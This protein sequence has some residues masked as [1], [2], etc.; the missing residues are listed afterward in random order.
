MA[1]RVL[2]I[3]NNL[4]QASYRLR[5]AALV[6]PLSR[7]GIEILVQV[8]PREWF[9]RRHLLQSAGDFDAVLLQRKMLDPWDMRTLRRRAKRIVYDVDDAVMYQGGQAGWFNRRLN[10]RRFIST[11]RRVDLVVAG[12]EY[13]ADLFRAQG[14]SAVVLPTCVDPNHYQVKASE[15]ANGATLVWIGSASTIPYLRQSLP[16]LAKAALAA[17]GLR[18]LTIADQSLPHSP[19]PLEHVTWSVETESAA[20]ARGDIGVAPTPTDRWT[21][22]KCGFKIVQY[23]AAGLPVIASPV[24]ANRE[25]V[26]DGKTGLLPSDEAAWVAAVAKLSGDAA[27]RKSMGRAGRQRVEEMFTL[28]K[29][30]DSWAKWLSGD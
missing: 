26:V 16:A 8:R 28:E 15:S 10:W 1:K 9:P 6:E 23:M 27:L 17:P 25:L 21:L 24:G 14:A 2:A 11:A 7:R 18:L 30:A 22:G 13:L 20:L 12:N 29:A 5:L 3:T 19:I 4:Q